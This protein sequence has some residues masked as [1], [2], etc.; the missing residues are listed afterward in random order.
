M[1]PETWSGVTG[2][3][4]LD[5]PCPDCALGIGTAPGPCRTCGDSGK[6]RDRDADLPFERVITRDGEARETRWQ[7]TEGEVKALVNGAPVVLLVWGPAHPPVAVTAG[8]PVAPEDGGIELL[9]KGHVYRALGAMWGEHIARLAFPSGDA[10]AEA[11]DQA[12]AAT[13][14]QP[15][16]P[17]TGNGSAREPRA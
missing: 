16:P 8:E 12:L 15:A 2:V 1:K 9:S 4:T 11:F 7:P 5:R 14:E 13:R 6:V 17:A 10:F 3:L